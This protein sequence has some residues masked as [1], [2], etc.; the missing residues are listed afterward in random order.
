MR[1]VKVGVGLLTCPG[2]EGYFEKADDAIQ[3]RLSAH[4]C[5][6]FHD[7]FREGIA[8]G[9]NHLFE[10]MLDVGCDWLFICED[11][12]IVLSPMAVDGYIEA[13]KQSGFQHLGFGQHRNQH[14]TEVGEV[15]TLWPNIVAPWSVYS[16]ECLEACGLMDEGFP[17]NLEHV[18]HTMR[19]AR[20]GYAWVPE[21]HKLMADA[22][23]SLDWLVNLDAPSLIDTSRFGEAQ[24]YWFA[25][26]P[27][28]YGM[29]WPWSPT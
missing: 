26:D 24:R 4:R 21:K 9:K 2:R 5:F 3:E 16:R 22:T 10:A 6:V 14:P 18:E 19:L 25:K 28:T 13:C 29:I 11:D 15:L 8:K 1:D 20:A 7:T 27:G 23:G 17:G 12:C